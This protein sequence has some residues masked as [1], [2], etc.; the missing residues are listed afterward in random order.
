MLTLRTYAK[1]FA[2]WTKADFDEWR[3]HN[4][5]NW[6][7]KQKAAASEPAINNLYANNSEENLS[8]KLL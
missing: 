7:T 2:T 4:Y 8:L 6:L 1:N 3:R 5:R